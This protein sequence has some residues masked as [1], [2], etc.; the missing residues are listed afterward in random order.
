MS[1]CDRAAPRFARPGEAWHCVVS[2]RLALRDRIKQ[3]LDRQPQYNYLD[4]II[5]SAWTWERKKANH[6]LIENYLPSNGGKL[7]IEKF[8]QYMAIT[9]KTF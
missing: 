7:K 4:R 5:L 6:Y 1:C 9:K 3:V 8:Y 2:Q